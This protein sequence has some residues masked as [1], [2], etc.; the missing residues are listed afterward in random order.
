VAVPM[1]FIV[2]IAAAIVCAIALRRTTFGF[3]VRVAAGSQEAARYSGM[4]TRR[5]LLVVM[6]ISGLLAGIG[7]ASQVGTSAHLLDPS[8]L[9]Q[10]QYGYTGIVVAALGA[11]DPI[12]T[13]FAAVL[14]GAIASA[15][16]QLEGVHFPVG[17]VGTIEGI[18]L[19]CVVS[20]A[21]LTLYRIRWRRV[22]GG[23][24]TG[25]TG[26]PGPAI[27]ALAAERE[28]AAS[29]GPVGQSTADSH[30]RVEVEPDLSAATK[31]RRGGA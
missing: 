29:G 4:S 25:H 28:L 13:I 31:R 18:I 16:T 17:L 19:F 3:R 24:I 20:A 5:L 26:S 2:G 8:G 23:P 21:L 30:Q 7:G 15:G 14:L 10:A 1:G 11:F 22:L 9:Q 6:I 12:A 27:A